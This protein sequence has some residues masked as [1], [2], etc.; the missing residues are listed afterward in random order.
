M[1]ESTPRPRVS[2]GLV[3]RN[4]RIEHASRL[5]QLVALESVARVA[6]QSTCP[7]VLVHTSADGL[8]A[9][10]AGWWAGRSGAL[11]A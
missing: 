4:R 5:L 8:L 9:S 11:P 10:Q 6:L 3:T 7:A 1:D 2:M